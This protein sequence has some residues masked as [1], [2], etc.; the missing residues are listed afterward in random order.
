MST[1]TRRVLA[2]AIHAV[3]EWVS[4]VGAVSPD[5]ERGRRYRALGRGSMLAFPPGAVF[6]ERWIA[7]GERTLFGP[8]VNLSVGMP[9]EPLDP[10]SPPV[11]VIGNRCN[12]GRGSSI[13]ARCSVVIE[14]DVTTAP[15]VYITDHNHTYD[16][17]DVPV[18]RQWPA[19]D[20][21][22]IGAG[23]WLGT[24]VTILPG[25]VLGRNVVVGAGSVVRGEFPDNAVIAGVP[26]KIVRRHVDGAWIPPIGPQVVRPP[27]DY[28]VHAPPTWPG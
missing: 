25:T 14:D 2:G 6:G 17:V 3:W 11:I 18:T 1:R 27:D 15:D 4:V 5:D 19:E 23:S 7:I 28:D 8:Q 26:A 24:G 20:P 9:G 12:I 10:E 21:V 22:R 16:V 13:A